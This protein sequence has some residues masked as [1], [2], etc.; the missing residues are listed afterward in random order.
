M[1]QKADKDRLDKVLQ[2]VE[3]YKIR[4][5]VA[6]ISRK[7]NRGKGEVSSYLNGNKPMSDNFYKTFMEEFPPKK[8]YDSNE[9]D[10]LLIALRMLEKANDNLRYEQ[11]TIRM[12]A[13]KLP[14][15]IEP[16]KNGLPSSKTNQ[17]AK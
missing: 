10:P 1:L 4:F 3:S 2:T 5:P 13:E 8:E 17:T 9:S 15:K 14:D 6:E 11:E 7:L 12:F 16:A